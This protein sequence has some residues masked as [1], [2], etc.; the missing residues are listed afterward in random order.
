MTLVTVEFLMPGQ[1]L[2]TRHVAL[3]QRHGTWKEEE[4]SKG[5]SAQRESEILSVV[6]TG[7][8]NHRSCRCHELLKISV[9]QRVI[10]LKAGDNHM[11]GDKCLYA[12]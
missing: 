2:H 3:L 8:L 6:F 4:G 7:D 9:S 1:Q 10:T 5:H 12:T 11:A